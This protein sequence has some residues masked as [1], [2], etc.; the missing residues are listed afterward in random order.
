MG[1][2][3]VSAGRAAG[4]PD[5][6]ATAGARPQ[7][8]WP[9]PV[10]MAG[11]FLIVLDFFVVNVALPSIQAGL[12]ASTGALEWVVAGYGLTFS[13]FLITSGRIGDRVGRRRAFAIGLALFA[14]ASAACG[15]APSP[16][17]LVAARLVQGLAG[18]LISASVLSLIGV[19]YTGFARAKA[20]SVY[21]MVMGVAAVGGQLL[22][23]ALIQANIAGEGW[24]AVFL[25]NLPVAAAALA[26]TRQLVP[27]SRAEHAKRIDVTGIVLVTFALTAVLLPLIQGREQSWPP[28]TWLSLGLAPMVLAALAW[29]QG[30][31]AAAGGEPL[32]DPV[33]F[34][35]AVFRAG[36]LTQLVYWCSQA[37]LYLVL[38]LYL[39]QGRG[40]DPLHAGLVFT[41]LAGA[42]LATSLRAPALT[43]RYGP[44]LITV[45]ALVM[46]AG[47]GLLLAAVSHVGVGGSAGFL[48]PG[49]GFIGAGMG[50][51]ITPLTMTTLAHA[52]PQRAGAVS[53][54]LSTMQQAGNSLGVAITGIIFFGALDYG[55]AHAF[56]LALAELA[57]LLL[58]VAA[59][60]RCLPR[61]GRSA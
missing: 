54:A 6:T 35:N 30:R 53:G 17:V 19:L 18:A 25:I 45:G 46:A 50:L 7:W 56:Q 4:S 12:H 58:A 51:C 20:V 14:L 23:G 37:P 22:G 49:L 10:L 26:L 21:G 2:A 13:A 60:A 43:L 32:L 61:P 38:A 33:L 39:Q 57:G 16:G 9:L 1:E 27:E 52:D 5:A 3:S 42:Y 34:K 47:L 29:H 11:T 59:L 41:I 36:L 44:I 55:Y 40:L 48:A 15:L 31:L 24:R 28:W 8:W